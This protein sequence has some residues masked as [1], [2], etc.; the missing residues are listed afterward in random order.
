MLWGGPISVNQSTKGANE[1]INSNGVRFGP[2]AFGRAARRAGMLENAHVRE[3]RLGGPAGELERPGNQCDWFRFAR[4]LR[5]K[6]GDAWG[7][8]ARVVQGNLH[9]AGRQK[10]EADGRHHHRMPRSKV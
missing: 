9:A 3:A 5:N 1:K 4:A 6:P 7:G 8:P 2:G 10:S